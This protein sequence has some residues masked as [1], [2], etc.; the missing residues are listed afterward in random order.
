MTMLLVQLPPSSLLRPELFISDSTR[1][2]GELGRYLSPLA[3]T[4]GEQQLP[5][6]EGWPLSLSLCSG[7][8]LHTESLWAQKG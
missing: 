7:Q 5:E 3:I 1:G 8:F 4:C 6:S 2:P